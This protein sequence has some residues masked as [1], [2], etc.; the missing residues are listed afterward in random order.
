[1]RDLICDVTYRAWAAKLRYI[2]LK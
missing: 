1:M 2:R